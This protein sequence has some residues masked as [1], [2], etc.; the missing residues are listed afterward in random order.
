[1]L[2]K[3]VRHAFVYSADGKL[4]WQNPPKNHNELRLKVAGSTGHKGYW[5]IQFDGKKYRR[6][7]LVFLYHH[8]RLPK[9]VCDHINR[10][11]DD[12]RIENLREVSVLENARNHSKFSVKKMPSGRF[13]ARLAQ[14]SL[15]TFNTREEAKERYFTER[16][17]QWGF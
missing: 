12:D 15:G 11:R 10:K 3:T 16:Q 6:A 5:Y 8:G 17:K 9:P 4:L 13:Q 14:K 7:H 2:L 1:M